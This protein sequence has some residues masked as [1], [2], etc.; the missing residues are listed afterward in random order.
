MFNSSNTRVTS[1]IFVPLLAVLDMIVWI[2]FILSS[3]SL[4]PVLIGSMVR[5][6]I[7]LFPV[8]TAELV[9]LANAVTP[10]TWRAE[11][12]ALTVSTPLANPPISILFAA[13][14]TSLRPLAE[15]D[16]FKLC[17]S[18]SRED[19]DVLI[20]DSNCLLSN[21]ISTTLLS[22]IVLIS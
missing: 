14:P 12:L 22:T 8:L 19:I 21:R 1:F 20:F 17:L 13:S 10:I 7:I 16:I 18:L 9:M 11:N 5:A 2:E 4:N 6:L 15:V 3:Y